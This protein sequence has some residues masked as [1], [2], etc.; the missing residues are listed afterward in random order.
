MRKLCLYIACSLD[1][2]IAKSNDD[3]NFLKLVEKEGEDYGYTEFISTVDTLIIGRKTYDWVRKNIGTVHYDNC[4][5][6]V[7]VIS[8]TPQPNLGRTIFY[9]EDLKNLIS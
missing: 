1:S 5:R 8:R 4:D 7:Y 3:L 6:D 9:S 2:Y